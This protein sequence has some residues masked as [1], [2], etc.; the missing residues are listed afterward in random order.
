MQTA[1]QGLGKGPSG[2]APQECTRTDN[3]LRSF[4]NLLRFAPPLQAAP[5]PSLGFR[6]AP[7]AIKPG[8]QTQSYCKPMLHDLQLR[9]SIQ[10]ETKGLCKDFNTSHRSS[11]RHNLGFALH[12]FPTSADFKLKP[13]GPVRFV[14]QPERC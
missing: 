1:P 10:Y 9:F 14:L 2:P 6:G 12:G 8:K 11:Q 4:L 7:C 3:L 5:A 13:P